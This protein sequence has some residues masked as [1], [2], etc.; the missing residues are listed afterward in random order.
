VNPSWFANAPHYNQGGFPRLRPDEEAAILHR[1]EEVLTKDDPRNAL[2]AVRNSGGRSGPSEVAVRN[3]LVMD[4][5]MIAQ[6]LAGSEGEKV[7][8]STLQK[9]AATLRQFAR[10]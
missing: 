1:G 8:V 7:I 2:N 6:A 9:N 5:S 3:V 4:P 10:G